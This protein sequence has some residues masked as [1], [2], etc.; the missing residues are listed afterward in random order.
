MQIRFKFF[1]IL[2]NQS[3]IQ[4]LAKRSS[5]SQRLN[6]PELKAGLSNEKT[7]CLSKARTLHGRYLAPVPLQA[8]LYSDLES[9][10]S[11]ALFPS[12][13][14]SKEGGAGNRHENSHGIQ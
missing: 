7:G 9:L 1:L 11:E 5:A 10:R 13:G 4:S 14:A 12:F 8:A 3:N 6:F 2:G